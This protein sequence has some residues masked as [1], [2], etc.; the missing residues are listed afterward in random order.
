MR[1]QIIRVAVSDVFLFLCAG[2]WHLFHQRKS[3]H[4]LPSVQRVD[5]FAEVDDVLE[6]MSR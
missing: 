5:R 1:V 3:G 4:S 2:A 6:L